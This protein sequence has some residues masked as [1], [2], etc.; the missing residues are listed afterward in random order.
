ML[1][2]HFAMRWD[3]SWLFSLTLIPRNSILALKL[4]FKTKNHLHRRHDLCIWS[5][6]RCRSWAARMHYQISKAHL[7]QHLVFAASPRSLHLICTWCIFEKWARKTCFMNEKKTRCLPDTVSI[8]ENEPTETFFFF[9]KSYPIEQI[10][11]SNR[12]FFFCF[13]LNLL[14]W[15]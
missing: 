12:F 1:R 5:R 8:F 4:A 13:L 10:L 6:F 7:P 2:W 15:K 11:L 9:K 3:S 14:F